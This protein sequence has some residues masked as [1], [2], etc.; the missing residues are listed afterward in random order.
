M[1]GRPNWAAR[2]KGSEVITDRE[3][4]LPKEKGW[5]EVRLLSKGWNA[6]EVL[7]EW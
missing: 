5:E 7:V 6:G 4:S 1:A 3:Q 2:L